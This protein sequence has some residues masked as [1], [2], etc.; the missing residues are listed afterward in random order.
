MAFRSLVCSVVVDDE[1]R[2]ASFGF[3]GHSE[4]RV[5]E[6]ARSFIEATAGVR[7]SAV[8]EHETREQKTRLWRGNRSTSLPFRAGSKDV[9]LDNDRLGC[10]K[11]LEQREDPMKQCQQTPPAKTGAYDDG[12]YGRIHPSPPPSAPLLA[13]FALSRSLLLPALIPTLDHFK[14]LK[15]LVLAN[16]LLVDAGLDLPR[17][18]SAYIYRKKLALPEVVVGRFRAFDAFWFRF[19]YLGIGLVFTLILFR[20]WDSRE[21]SALSKNARCAIIHYATTTPQTTHQMYYSHAISTSSST[22][23]PFYV[24]MRTFI[25]ARIR[26]FLGLSRAQIHPIPY[27]TTGVW[28]LIGAFPTPTIA[29][30]AGLDWAKNLLIR[31]R[32]SRAWHFNELNGVGTAWPISHA[33]VRPMGVGVVGVI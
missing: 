27:A 20:D 12:G 30:T 16:A 7:E 29:P 8:D 5:R 21:A 28:L 14:K 31:C 13:S 6:L 3:V 24:Q 32:G 26:G 2:R 11:T 23:E 22:S 18:A 9:Q 19:N 1:K 4:E 25:Q 17:S 15:V 33:F 10:H